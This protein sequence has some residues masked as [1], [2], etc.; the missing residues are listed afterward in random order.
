MGGV[1]KEIEEIKN[2][3]EKV[4]IPKN[5]IEQKTNKLHQYY[6]KQDVINHKQFGKKRTN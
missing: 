1:K 5:A 4:K 3:M 2:K 6:Q